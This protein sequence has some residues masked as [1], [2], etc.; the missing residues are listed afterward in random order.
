MKEGDMSAFDQLFKLHYED[1]VSQL[2]RK[3]YDLELSE[4][5]IQNIFIEFWSNRKELNIQNS[6]KA[7]LSTS[8]RN[9]FID[10]FR[11]QKSIVRKEENYLQNTL[12]LNIAS[13]EEELLT[14]ENLDNIYDKIAQLPAQSKHIF[15]LS[16]FSE[17]SYQDIAEE[18]GVSVKTVEYHISKALRILR[19]TIFS[20]FL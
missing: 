4:D 12:H 11:K 16:R 20:L 1:L 14:K 13:P 17:M 2:Y 19:K 3:S 15:Q 5:I 10:H 18:L 7:Y 9:R 6:I 8:A